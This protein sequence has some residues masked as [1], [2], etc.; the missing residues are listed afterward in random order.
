MVKR[1]V[2]LDVLR[3][4]HGLLEDALFSLPEVGTDDTRMALV[5]ALEMLEEL[6]PDL[7]EEIYGS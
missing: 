5:R 1:T 7:A 6:V 3:E 2:D 4:V